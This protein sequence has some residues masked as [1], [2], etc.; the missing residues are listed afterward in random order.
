MVS[1]FNDLRFM[2]V[3]KIRF[4][5]CYGWSV[6]LYGMEWLYTKSKHYEEAGAL[7]NVDLSK[8]H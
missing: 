4:I 7:Q 1:T 6:S 2:C 5:K 8:N 3:C